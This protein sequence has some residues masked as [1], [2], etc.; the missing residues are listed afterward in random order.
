MA[1]AT[2]LGSDMEYTLAT[3]LGELF[4]IDADIDSPA[5]AGDHVAFDLARR[6]VTLLRG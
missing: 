1:K 3:P 4:A 6:G 5:A 2:Y